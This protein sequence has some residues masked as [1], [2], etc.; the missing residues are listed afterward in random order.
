MADKP[1]T[2][3]IELPPEA[4]TAPE[5]KDERP[6]EAELRKSGLTEHEIKAAKDQKLVRD[7]HETKP[8]GK[9]GD[10]KEGT[11]PVEEKKPP[12]KT[13]NPIEFDLTPEQEAEFLKAFGPGSKPRGLYFRMKNERK[14]RQ[15]AEQRSRDLETRIAAL[16]AAKAEPKPGDNGELEFTEEDLSK[17]VTLKT[18]LEL[19][20]RRQ[21]ALEGQQASLA[22]ERDALVAAHAEQEEEAKAKHEDFDAVVTDAKDVIQHFEEMFDDPDT[23]AE[24]K[25]LIRDLKGAATNAHKRKPD[26]LS[27]AEIAYRLGL[28]HPE[29]GRTADGGGQP[30]NSPDERGRMTPEQVLK[31]ERTA[32][33]RASSASVASGTG[34][35]GKRHIAASQVTGEIYMKMSNE[36]QLAFREKHPAEYAKLIRS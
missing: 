4:A 14:A 23:V 34:D 28:M 31:A 2:D 29:H 5:P 22:K 30:K 8:D 10:G 33:R 35:G 19:Q 26:D 7:E 32:T 9:T 12:Q 25:R 20:E 36:Q 17:P 15:A 24:V 11:P 3:T 13:P 6:T 18:L 27:Y 16:E 21:K 1:E